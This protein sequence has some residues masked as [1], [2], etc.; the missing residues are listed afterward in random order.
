MYLED[1]WAQYLFHS[2]STCNTLKLYEPFYCRRFDDVGRFLKLNLSQL[3]SRSISLF[4]ALCW[5][6]GILLGACFSVFVQGTVFRTLFL[7]VVS[8]D[9]FVQH[10]FPVALICVITGLSICFS[11]VWILMP[12][13]FLKGILFSFTWIGFLGAFRASAWLIRCMFMFADLLSVPLLWF[14]WLR[15]AS[16]RRVWSH[17]FICFICVASIYFVD[18]SFVL[19]FLERLL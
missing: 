7:S 15:S 11:Q 19:P 17:S 5:I 2:Q 6:A 10:V 13:V 3:S 16:D 18:Y 9:S 12:L 4:L 14:L 1:W 8:T